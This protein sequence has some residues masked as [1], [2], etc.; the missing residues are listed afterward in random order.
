MNLIG[1]IR[2]SSRRQA[3]DG[4]SLDAQREKL[5]AY[6]QL[7]EHD[8]VRIEQDAA[9]SGGK[10][11]RPG[12]QRALSALEAGSAEGIITAKLDRLTRSVSDLGRLLESHFGDD[13]PYALICVID[14][15]DTSSANGRLAANIL[16]S[17]AQWER[18]VAAERTATIREIK[19]ENGEYVGGAVPF[20]YEIEVVDGVKMLAPCQ[21]EREAIDAAKKLRQIMSATLHEIAEAL[22][23]QGFR[24]REGKRWTRQSVARLLES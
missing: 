23:Q 21:R 7:H 11:E 10:L 13:A 5:E 14:Q 2:V 15:M 16:M 19:R 8:L 24:R 3:D 4:L 12:L 22:N 6:C 17:V 9:K 20:G 18:E 1:Y